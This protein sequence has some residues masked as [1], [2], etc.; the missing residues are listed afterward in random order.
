MTTQ[1]QSSLFYNSCI[2]NIT[3]NH[4]HIRGYYD[5][6]T[7]IPSTPEELDQIIELSRHIGQQKKFRHARRTGYRSCIRPKKCYT[8]GCPMNQLTQWRNYGKALTKTTDAQPT[9]I[10]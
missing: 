4:L 7:D 3:G 10:H 2:A 1:N 8:S 9:T 5:I 6:Q